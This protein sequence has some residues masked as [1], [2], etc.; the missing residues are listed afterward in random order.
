MDETC[1]ARA[2]AAAVNVSPVSPSL[3][4]PISL[5]PLVFQA[6]PHLWLRSLKGRRG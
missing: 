1:Q 2:N 4:P 5:G 6:P 3:D